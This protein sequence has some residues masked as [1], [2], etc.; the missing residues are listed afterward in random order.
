MGKDDEPFAVMTKFGPTLVGPTQDAV[1]SYD[2]DVCAL[3]FDYED[4]NSVNHPRFPFLW[5]V[6]ENYLLSVELPW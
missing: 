4:N 5:S 3:D 2:A 6:R 1:T